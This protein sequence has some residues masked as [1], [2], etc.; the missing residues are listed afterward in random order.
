[1]NT[2]DQIPY[3]VMAPL[4]GSKKL[5]SPAERAHH[6]EV[7][8]R[9][10]GFL[11]PDIEWYLTQQILPPVARLCEPIEGASQTVLAEKLGLDGTKYK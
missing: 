2:G 8:L 4:E 6:P 11:K 3:V 10:G 1:M 5:L 9:S 7:I